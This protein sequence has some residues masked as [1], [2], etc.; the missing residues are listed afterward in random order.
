MNS[1]THHPGRLNDDLF[2]RAAAAYYRAPRAD[3][4]G[5]PAARHSYLAEHE[6][7][8]YVVLASTDAFLAVYRIRQSGMLKRMRRWPK[9]IEARSAPSPGASLG[10]T[11][12]EP[13]ASPPQ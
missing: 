9:D 3:A 4:D 7:R 5:Q 11:G 13:P 8:Q 2:A 12:P 1:E 10:L 6:G